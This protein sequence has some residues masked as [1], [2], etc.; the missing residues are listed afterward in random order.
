MISIVV[1][2]HNAEKFLEETIKSVMAQTYTDWELLL[3]KSF[4]LP[5]I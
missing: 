1:P 3:V 5:N 2:V 4:S